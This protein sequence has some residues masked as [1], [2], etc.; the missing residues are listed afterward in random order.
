MKTNE[1]IELIKAAIYCDLRQKFEVDEVDEIYRK[2]DRAV[3]MSEDER[4]KR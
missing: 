3:A 2:I 1:L 4:I